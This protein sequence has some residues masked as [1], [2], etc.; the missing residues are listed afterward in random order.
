MKL[1]TWL[2]KKRM[3][4]NQYDYDYF[5]KIFADQDVRYLK[6]FFS[7][8]GTDILNIR[9]E[10]YLP[11]HVAAAYNTI[12]VLRFLIKMGANADSKCDNGNSV[13]HFSILNPS[14]K[15]F[16][17]LL[18]LGIDIHAKNHGGMTV[19]H[20][21]FGTQNTFHFLKLCYDAGIDL[22]E[23]DDSGCKPIHYAAERGASIKSFNF[24]I[25]KNI[26]L[27]NRDNLG[28][29]ALSYA[30]KYRNLDVINLLIK[31]SKSVWNAKNIKGRDMIQIVSK[32]R[33]NPEIIALLLSKGG[34][35]SYKDNTGLQAIH[36]AIKNTSSKNLLYLIKNGSNVNAKD[37][38]GNTPLHYACLYNKLPFCKILIENGAMLNYANL[39]NETP[40]HIAAE[41][42]SGKIIDL[43]YQNG[44]NFE[45][46][47]DDFEKP[48]NIAI[49]LR[50]FSISKNII[51]KTNLNSSSA[52][53][54][55]PILSAFNMNKIKILKLLIR[56]GHPLNKKSLDTDSIVNLACSKNKT[57]I[58]ELLYNKGANFEEKDVHGRT[59]THYACFSSDESVIRFLSG[60][61]VDFMCQ[62][63]YGITPVDILCYNRCLGLLQ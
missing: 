14:T 8:N 2:F 37:Y 35:L 32:Y 44:G 20:C 59:C 11:I 3:E 45:K 47:N 6:D 16:E 55:N 58:L 24:L 21:L 38:E 42:S 17:Y 56:L 28:N 36:L 1:L 9:A 30:C 31:K 4:Q 10:G 12:D 61:K 27:D 49:R 19:A 57:D 60:K 26:N 5:C 25:S 63:K 46:Q 53:Q 22:D 33:K 34:S 41:F 43:I 54:I 62:D 7:A 18:D 48:I 40:V 23:S 15:N 13:I 39:S 29:T 50:G 51:T 52:N